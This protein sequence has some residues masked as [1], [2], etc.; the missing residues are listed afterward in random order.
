MA[1]YEQKLNALIEKYNLDI[2][3]TTRFKCSLRDFT[4]TRRIGLS[5]RKGFIIQREK[6]AELIT[7]DDDFICFL[8][9]NANEGVIKHFPNGNET[10]K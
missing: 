10:V 4:R 5:I 8:D 1:F 6:L 7:A 3:P 2:R 9:A